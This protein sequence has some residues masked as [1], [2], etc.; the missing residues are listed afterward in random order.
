VASPLGRIAIGSAANAGKGK[1][2]VNNRQKMI[3]KPSFFIRVSPRLGRWVR[4][5]KRADADRWIIDGDA[6][7]IVASTVG[8]GCCGKV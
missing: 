6:V 7:V 8:Q 5:G 3:G 2:N 1:K 4:Q